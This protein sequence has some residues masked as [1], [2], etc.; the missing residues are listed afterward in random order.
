MCISLTAEEQVLLKAEKPELYAEV[1]RASELSEIKR[2]V[3]QVRVEQW[4]YMRRMPPEA[5]ALLY[6]FPE[7]ASAPAED[8]LTEQG[9]LVPFP[10]ELTRCSPF[11]PLA[12]QAMGKR[13]FMQG[14]LIAS[15]GWGEVRYTGPRL[16]VFEED[17]L[18]AVLFLVSKPSEYRR[19]EQRGDRFT[20]AWSGPAFPLLKL[21]GY[22]RASKRDYKRLIDALSLLMSAVVELSVSDG[23]TKSGRKRPPRYILLEHLLERGRWLEEEKVLEVTP[24]PLLLGRSR[25]SLLDV[26]ER[27]ALKGQVAKALYRFIRGQEVWSGSLMTLAEVLHMDTAQPKFTLRR[28]LAEAIA[29]LKKHGI[30]TAAGSFIKGDVVKLTAKKVILKKSKQKQ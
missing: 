5:Q 21:M 2:Q 3:L 30:V 23:R 7:P 20:W 17:V 4:R 13:D 26:E 9:R 29:E 16:S 25:F 24:N 11:F 18:L 6:P 1:E 8:P 19:R 12:K 10:V 15:T 14:E 27:L 28:Q 22:E